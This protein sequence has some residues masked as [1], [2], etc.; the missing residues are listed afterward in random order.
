[1]VKVD[2]VR[3]SANRKMRISKIKQIKSGSK[4]KERKGTLKSDSFNLRLH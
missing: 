4:A 2:L 1:M 3:K